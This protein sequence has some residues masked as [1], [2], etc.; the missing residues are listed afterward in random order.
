MPHSVTGAPLCPTFSPI[1]SDIIA[2]VRNKD[3]WIVSMKSGEEHQLT[4]QHSSRVD[5]SMLYVLAVH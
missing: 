4:E 2:F 5:D 1:S 3:L